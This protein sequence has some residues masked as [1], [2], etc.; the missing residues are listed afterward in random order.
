MSTW[1]DLTLDRAIDLAEDGQTR[2]LLRRLQV[3]VTQSRPE[4]ERFREWCDRA[5]RLFY[6]E[7][8]HEKWG[9]DLWASDPSATTPGR[10]HVSVNTPA[11]YVEIP[12]ALQAVEPI[13]NMLAT[14]TTPESREAASA[15]ERIYTA[16]K[17]AEAYELKNHKAIVVKELY[18]RTASRIYWDKD[19]KR[20]CFEVVEQPR[21]LYLGWKSD[22]YQRLEWCAYVTRMDPNAVLEQ[23][24]VEVIVKSLGED[25]VTPYVTLDIE[26][27]APGRPWL[28]FG[29]A[30]IE[31]WDYWYREPRRKNGK[32]QGMDTYNVVLA[33]N[34][35]VQGPFKYAEYDGDLPVRVLFNGFIP[36]V[37]N[38]RPA[39][40]DMEHLIREKME[41]I[42]AA[43][44]MI[45]SAVAGDY[46]QLVGPEAPSAVS[47]GVK[48]KRNTVIAPGPGNR[49][50]T[51]TPFIAQFQLEQ[52]LG[53]IDRE[54]AVV[55]GLND[56]LLGLAPA[57]V[58]SSSKAINALIANYES[59]LS[60]R[61]KLLYQWRREN[62]ELA[63]KVYAHKNKD[64][65]AVVAAGGGV[66]DVRDPSLSPR[67]DMETMTRALNAMNGKIASQ[68]TA[69]DWIGIDDPET[70]Q[71]LIREERTD[72]TMFPAEVQVMAQLLAA[73]QSLNLQAPAGVQG[74]AQQQLASGQNDLRSALGAAT[75]DN[76]TSS[77]LAGDQGVLPPEAA[78]PGA[79]PF[80]QPPAGGASPQ[81]GAG[82][83]QTMIKDGKASSRILT[84]QQ[85]GRR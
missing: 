43:S 17:A 74:Q 12:S 37:P 22:E 10:S 41:R 49:I 67:D 77:Q 11:A 80:A 69:M 1:V 54:E 56:L 35:I 50:E 71:D 66:L 61:R 82:L 29:P 18:G 57:Q 68:R 8:V 21:N 45:A 42:T 52:Y 44:Q 70:E 25:T 73:L 81:G 84:Q 78:T 48:P 5:D 6:A 38:G 58:L 7:D 51:I 24:G 32:F 19:K 31:V 63:E 2:E 14:D 64:V 72:A 39:L 34:Q 20:P 13:E 83:A 76:S 27:G 53:R 23:Y 36:G 75:P 26:E 55:S 65:R 85:L 79:I 59:R 28:N 40:Y 33:G 3:G 4:M 15:L 47:P 9:A 30:R 16:W 46:W 60:M 62:W